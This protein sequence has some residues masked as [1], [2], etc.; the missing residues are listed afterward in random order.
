M[1]EIRVLV[2]K[3]LHE[4][5]FDHVAA[6]PFVVR[7]NLSACPTADIPTMSTPERPINERRLISGG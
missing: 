5:R 1:K 4:L 2:G 6:R 3:F 7:R